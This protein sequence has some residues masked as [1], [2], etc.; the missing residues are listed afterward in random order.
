MTP[1]LIIIIRAKRSDSQD[2]N[3]IL[4]KTIFIEPP[5]TDKFTNVNSMIDQFGI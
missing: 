4:A 3:Q 1:I 5:F 2:V